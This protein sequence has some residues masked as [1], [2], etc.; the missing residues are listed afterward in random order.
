MIIFIKSILS[1]IYKDNYGFD[2]INYMKQALLKAIAKKHKFKKKAEEYSDS[3]DS[4]IF[5]CCT[6]VRNSSSSK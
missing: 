5:Q 1:K 4:S 3:D 2:Y 6:V